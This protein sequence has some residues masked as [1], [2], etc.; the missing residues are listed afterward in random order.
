M[1]TEHQAKK[2]FKEN[3]NWFININ[4]FYSKMPV[5]RKRW[6]FASL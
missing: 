2:I 5:R 3:A 1:Q 4:N 6:E